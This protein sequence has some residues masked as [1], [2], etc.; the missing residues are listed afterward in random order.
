M[1]TI[2][3][4]RPVAL[5]ADQDIRVREYLAANLVAD[6]FLVTVVNCTEAAVEACAATVP[7]V[8]IVAVN[9]GSGLEFARQ[10]RAGIPR[11]DPRLPLML[12]GDA[13]AERAL[14]A[15]A[16]DYVGDPITSYR[17]LLARVHALVRRSNLNGAPP[18][19]GAQVG[20][21][22]VDYTARE[23]RLRDQRIELS[24]KEYGLL[25]ALLKDPTAVLT[26]EALLREVWGYRAP[27]SSRTLDSHA[28]RLRQKLGVHGDVF[29]VNLWGVGYKL[30]ESTD[31]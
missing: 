18:A 9:T 27:A 15:G 31:L 25:C 5:I 19:A 16:D 17:E 30:C 29:V 14:N 13:F 3:L 12:V 26:K 6:G 24:Q 2:P 23:V 28:C 10:V 7:D 21:L 1:T 8:A 4:V 20:V 22:R 11:V